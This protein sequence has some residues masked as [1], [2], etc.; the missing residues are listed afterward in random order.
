M[1]VYKRENSRYGFYSVLAGAITSRSQ[2]NGKAILWKG[3]VGDEI[4]QYTTKHRVWSNTQST[5]HKYQNCS[6][7]LLTAHGMNLRVI[8]MDNGVKYLL[9][10]R[11]GFDF[12]AEKLWAKVV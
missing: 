1:N 3:Q 11:L 4:V 10:V 8:T 7:S 2:H 9:S 5:R 6:E 12:R